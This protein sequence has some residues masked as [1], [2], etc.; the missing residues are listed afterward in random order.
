VN[1]G[2]SI[3]DEIGGIMKALIL[4]NAGP[5]ELFILPITNQGG[6]DE[7]PKSAII[8]IKGNQSDTWEV[9]HIDELRRISKSRIVSKQESASIDN[10]TF[11]YVINRIRKYY[12][13][14]YKIF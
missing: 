10:E 5:D 2:F 4:G 13:N 14:W 9:A 1:F 8:E 3:G 12:G 6:S 7:N 11:M